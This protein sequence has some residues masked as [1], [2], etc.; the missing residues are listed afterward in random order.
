MESIL[1]TAFG[2]QVN[3]LKGEGDE[4]TGIAA[5]IFS[6]ANMKFL[7]WVVS[8]DCM[9][10]YCCIIQQYTFAAQL[11]VLYTISGLMTPYLKFTADIQNIYDTCLQLIQAR[12]Q[13]TDSSV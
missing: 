8:I 6:D 1:A 10:N 7:I 12:R 3:V 2:R 11:P 4:L 13:T 9:C 5:A